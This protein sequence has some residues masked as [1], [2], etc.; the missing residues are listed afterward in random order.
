MRKI[1][2]L[3]YLKDRVAIVT[4]GDGYLGTA[5]SFALAEAGAKVI[6]SDIA[7]SRVYQI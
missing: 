7:S 3:F 4:G 1:S 5:E 6:V 2:E